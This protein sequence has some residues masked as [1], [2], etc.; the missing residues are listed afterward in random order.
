METGI[1]ISQYAEIINKTAIYPQEVNK[2]G[3]AYTWLGL[4]EEFKEF[5]EKETNQDKEGML[6]EAGDV[7]WY[8]CALCKE[9]GIDFEQLLTHY[10][11]IIRY[12]LPK[13]TATELIYELLTFSGNVKKFYRDGKEININTLEYILREI[14]DFVFE[15]YEEEDIYI[16]LQKNY[17]KLIKRRETNTLHGDGDN[18]EDTAKTV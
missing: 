9:T 7:C 2:F 16:I 17:E 5:W 12:Q 4:N 13:L 6:K 15:N 1:T 8:I 14:L 10:I 11:K 3:I 18:R